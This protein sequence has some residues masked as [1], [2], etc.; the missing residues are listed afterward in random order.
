MPR[1]RLIGKDK[2][3]LDQEGALF[4]IRGM[5]PPLREH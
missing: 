1:N 4:L 3:Q 2:G 5:N